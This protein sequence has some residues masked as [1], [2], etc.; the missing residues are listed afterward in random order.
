[1]D[2]KT[3]KE[4]NDGNIGTFLKFVGE[5]MHQQ[6]RLTK[7]AMD[8]AERSIGNQVNDEPKEEEV[9]LSCKEAEQL[10]KLTRSAMDKLSKPDPKSGKVFLRKLG[11]RYLKSDLDDYMKSE[12]YR[13][14]QKKNVESVPAKER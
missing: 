14:G 7:F 5:F 8:A 3:L 10:S 13:K 9:W 2:E 12:R 1:M 4:L 11:S 6:S